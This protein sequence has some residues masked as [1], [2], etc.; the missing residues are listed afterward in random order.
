MQG[1]QILPLSWHS[2]GSAVAI[3]IGTALRCHRLVILA[4]RVDSVNDAFSEILNS[5]LSCSVI[6]LMTLFGRHIFL[7][8]GR[9]R[10]H[11]LLTLGGSFVGQTLSLK[12]KGIH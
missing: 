5:F 7:I 6:I 4:E 2:M 8:F 11:L 10:R 9:H 12:N 1:G 3:V